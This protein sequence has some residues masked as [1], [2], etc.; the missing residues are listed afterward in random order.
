MV[1]TRVRGDAVT[2]LPLIKAAKLWA[3]V[4]QM[5]VSVVWADS[6]TSRWPVAK[7]A[8]A[9]IRRP[10]RRDSY[11]ALIPPLAL[12]FLAAA[13]LLEEL[14]SLE[15][16]TLAAVLSYRPDELVTDRSDAW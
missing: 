1:A 11:A 7:L 16:R 6:A 3:K 14:N 4:S 8:R 9:A 15:M 10:A 5:T 12:S 2:D 13:P